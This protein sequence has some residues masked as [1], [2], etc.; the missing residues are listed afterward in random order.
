MR[1]WPG[2]ICDA[3]LTIVASGLQGS[4]NTRPQDTGALLQAGLEAT[5]ALLQ[6]AHAEKGPSYG[7]RQRAFSVRD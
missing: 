5:F 2:A 7:H 4:C 1:S 6:A 3:L